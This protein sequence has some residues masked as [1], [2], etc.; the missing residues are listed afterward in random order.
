MPI[1]VGLDT[2]FV[3]GLIDERNVWHA[4]AL[5]LPTGLQAGDYRLHRIGQAQPVEIYHLA[6][7]ATLEDDLRDILDRKVNVFE[8]V[9]GEMDMILGELTEARD[10]E[11]L[12]FEMWTHARTE[13]DLQTSMEPLSDTLAGARACRRCTRMTRRSWGRTVSRSEDSWP[14]LFWERDGPRQRG[15]RLAARW[16]RRSPRVEL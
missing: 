13:A 1:Q 10:F 15:R 14:S 9:I 4:A 3:V 16:P 5:D 12:L 11:D 7:V 2:S 8:S 6:A